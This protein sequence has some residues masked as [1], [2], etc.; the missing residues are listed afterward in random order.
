MVLKK[1]IQ[2]LVFRLRKSV[3]TGIKK[4]TSQ[5]VHQQ[6]ESTYGGVWHSSGDYYLHSTESKWVYFLGC[7]IWRL[8]I[9]TSRKFY[10]AEHT[11]LDASPTSE[12]VPL[13]SAPISNSVPTL[14]VV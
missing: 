11:L 2:S 6:F 3:F 5:S 10:E 9:E 14:R 7:P 12:V 1:T 4:S 8:S 13:L